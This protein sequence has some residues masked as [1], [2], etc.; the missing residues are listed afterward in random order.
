[1]VFGGVLVIHGIFSKGFGG[2][3]VYDMGKTGGKLEGFCDCDDDGDDDGDDD[4]LWDF[5]L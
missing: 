3:R 5:R 1:M 4:V 2:M